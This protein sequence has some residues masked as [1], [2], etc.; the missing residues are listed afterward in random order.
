MAS[1]AA[2]PRES[3]NP[4]L[5]GNF[6]PV[7]KEVTAERLPVRGEIPRELCGRLL[8]IGPNP[9]AP[10]PE[11]HHWFA[12]YGMVHGLRLR[13]GRAEWY[14]NRYVRS[15]GVTQAFGWPEV[16]GP[17]HGMGDG[18][19]NTNVIAHGGRSWALV[20]AGS[21]PVE[22]SYE[23]ETIARRDFDG[24]L[25]GS[26]TAHPKRD[27]R[28]GELH[29]VTYYW[30]WDHLQYMVVGHDARVRKLV[31]VPVPGRP[32]VH[33]M[34]L[35]ETKALLFDLPVHFD[36]QLIESGAA[37]PYRWN[38]D[39]APR[40]GVLPRDG[41]AEDVRW[42]EA[43]S[44]YV[45]HP[46]NAFD[47]PDGRVVVDVVKHPKMFANDLLG[48][49]EGESTLWRWTLDP[50]RG[51]ISEEQLDDRGQEFPR[52]DERLVGK[53]YRYGYCASFST[54]GQ[55][56]P[57]L[58]H[59]LAKGTTQV[60]EYGPG[61]VTL[62]AVFVPR[63][64]DSAEDDGWLLSYVYDAN[65]DASDVVILDAQDFTG[66]PV[67]EI[68]LPQRVPFGFHGNWAPDAG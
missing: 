12:G 25:P 55:H 33:D 46:L 5:A 45:Y 26:F 58:K 48:P 59:D 39:F 37:F 61:R 36:I 17:R 60:H 49:N 8:R 64:E 4:Y 68:A 30:E 62:E 56:G 50:A 3:S 53:P 47:L 19:A 43:P 21:P 23:L 52:H 42:C 57:L 15:D 38:P 1:A 31:K 6:A 20:E 27:P 9:I 40:V 29:A 14:R 7:G 35:T 2:L 65:R 67:A 13:G 10:N 16:P 28:T 66:R 24:T 22:L 41:G 51:R 34:A 63:S 54:G 32:M 11:T 44:C 18:S